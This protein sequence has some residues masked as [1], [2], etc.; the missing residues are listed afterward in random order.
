ML[1]FYSFR[2]FER[3]SGCFCI[4]IFIIFIITDGENSALLSSNNNL[5]VSAVLQ[6]PVSRPLSVSQVL[7]VSLSVFVIEARCV[8]L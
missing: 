7:E 5:H 2:S 8:N 1:H 4:I 6:S 3:L